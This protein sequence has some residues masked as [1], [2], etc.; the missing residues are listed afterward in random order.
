MFVYYYLGYIFYFALYF[1]R[2]RS[3]RREAV[4]TQEEHA[5]LKLRSN[6]ADHCVIIPTKDNQAPFL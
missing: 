2:S 3:T 5:R 6:S 4:Q 1:W